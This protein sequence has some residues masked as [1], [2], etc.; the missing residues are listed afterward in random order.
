MKL[1]QAL[2]DA[3][4]AFSEWRFPAQP[5]EGAAAMYTDDGEIL[6]STALDVPAGSSVQL[7]HEVGAMCEAYAKK[8]RITATVCVSRQPDGRFIVIGGLCGVCMERMWLWGGDV[9]IAVPL[10]EDPTRWRAITLAEAHPFYWRKF[11]P[12]QVG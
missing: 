9:E 7:C 4:I 8:K 10:E 11:L 2:V 3:A 1:D 5:Y 6:I 12:R